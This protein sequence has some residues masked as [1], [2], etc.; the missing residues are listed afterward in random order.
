MGSADLMERKLDRRVETLVLVRDAGIS[1][2]MR[3]VIFARL[4]S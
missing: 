4:P 3:E 2:H 1:R